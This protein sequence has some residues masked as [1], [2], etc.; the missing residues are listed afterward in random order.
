MYTSVRTADRVYLWGT[1]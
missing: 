1:A